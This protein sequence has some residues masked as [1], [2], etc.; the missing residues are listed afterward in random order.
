MEVVIG[1]IAITYELIGTGDK[2]ELGKLNTAERLEGSPPSRADI[3]S[4]DSSW[5]SE[6]RPPPGSGLRHRGNDR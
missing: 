4:N 2:L 1:A 5:R 6:M 3:V